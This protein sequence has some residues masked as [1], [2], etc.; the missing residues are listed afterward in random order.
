MRVSSTEKPAPSSPQDVRDLA[1]GGRARGRALRRQHLEATRLE[2]KVTQIVL[3]TKGHRPP[4][5]T[6]PQQW[7]RWFHTTLAFRGMW[8]HE[9][10]VKDLCD[11][12]LCSYLQR[13][14]ESPEKLETAKVSLTAAEGWSEG[15]RQ[16]AG[17]VLDVRCV[18]MLRWG[19]APGCQRESLLRL[20]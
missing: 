19:P 2:T 8:R 18:L 7:R 5:L 3:S 4:P 17:C 9:G 13:W 10:V 14:E 16:A 20:P 15:D 12:Q 11:P 6:V 1:A